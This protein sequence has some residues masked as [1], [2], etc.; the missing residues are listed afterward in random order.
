MSEAG[1]L[2]QLVAPPYDVITPEQRV[3]LWQRSPYN[4]VHLTLP[5]DAEDAGRELGDW[6]ADGIVTRDEQPA[7]WLLSQEDVGPDGVSRTRSG[8]V[9]SLR[10]EPYDTG[11]V[12]PHER[13]HAGRRRDGCSCCARRG[14]SS[15][16]LSPLR[17]HVSARAGARARPAERR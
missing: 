7:Y 15:S 11:V 2:E 12:L 3:E 4:V 10:A 14:R 6:R 17:G 16:R 13:T 9:A 5:D 1:P 8:I